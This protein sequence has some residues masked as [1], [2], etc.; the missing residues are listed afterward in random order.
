MQQ[1]TCTIDGCGKPHR[2]RGLCASHWNA[3]YRKPQHREVPCAAC[4]TMVVKNAPG[5]KRRPVC[6]DRCRYS[7][8]YG[9]FPEDGKALVGPVQRR[10]QPKV[11]K[12]R[13]RK[14]S[15]KV[16]FVA[17]TCEWCGIGFLHD[18]HVTGTLG[19]YCTKVHA[20]AASRLRY[21]MGR[22][23]FAITRTRRLA[24]YNRDDWTCQLCG[25]RV[26]DDL[27]PGHPMSPSL[28]HIEPQS[29]ALIPDHSESNL[30]LSHLI[31]NSIRGDRAA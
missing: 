12:R 27:P 26:R 6:S 4:G 30:R 31:C 7:V 17:C 8:T 10:W 29:W 23:Q 5:I 13:E 15:G 14:P 28:D 24:I 25:E 1:R 22:G 2:A 3:A 19:R 18:M 21:R 20:K 11:P 16:R 9:K